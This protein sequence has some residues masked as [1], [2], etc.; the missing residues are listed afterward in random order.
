M[1]PPAPDVQARPDQ[2]V[3][4]ATLGDKDALAWLYEQYA[5]KVRRFIE[6]RTAGNRELADDLAQDTWVKVARSIMQYDTTKASKVGFEGWLFTIARNEINTHFTRRSRR[7]E[8]LT[9]E[10]L[11]HDTSDSSVSPEES[12]ENSANATRMAAELAALPESQRLCLIHRFHS[13]LSLAETAAL[14]GKNVN[15]IKALQTRA[16]KALAKR[17]GDLAPISVPVTFSNV[18][19]SSPQEVGR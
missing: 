8:T 18:G 10:M 9:A 16:M 19:Q 12:A 6:T 15:A 14:M 1:H 7:K 3:H 2:Y 13:G 11:D 4:A 5:D 17:V